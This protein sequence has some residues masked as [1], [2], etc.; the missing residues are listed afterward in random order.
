[1]AKDDIAVGES[2]YY[3]K[4]EVYRE[5]ESEYCVKIYANSLTDAQAIIKRGLQEGIIQWPVQT[6]GRSRRK[7]E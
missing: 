6:A 4:Y 1:M 7:R 5:E 2:L 3:Y